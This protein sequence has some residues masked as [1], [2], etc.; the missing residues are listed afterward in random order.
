MTLIHSS[1]VVYNVFHIAVV[2]AQSSRVGDG[3][4]DLQ[5]DRNAHPV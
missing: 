4:A 3:G 2:S 1:A 5:A